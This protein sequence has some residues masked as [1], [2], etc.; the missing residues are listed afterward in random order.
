MTL[1]AHN[2]EFIQECKR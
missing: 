1:D 2:F